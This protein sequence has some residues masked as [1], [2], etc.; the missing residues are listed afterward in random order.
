MATTAFVSPPIITGIDNV[1]RAFDGLS[2]KAHKKILKTALRAAMRPI[3]KQMK[4]D[5]SNKVKTARKGVGMTVKTKQNKTLVAKVGFGVGKKKADME[6]IVNKKRTENSPGV[7]IGP[8]NVHWWI[9]G[10][11]DRFTGKRRG[12]GARAGAV[13]RATGSTKPMQPNLAKIAAATVQAES[14]KK[15]RESAMKQVRAEFNRLKK[16]GALANG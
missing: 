3:A 12:G 11:D 1:I 5:L 2:D 6:K 7:G 9:M 10:T 15:A 14:I 4:K 8:T 16:K 13:V